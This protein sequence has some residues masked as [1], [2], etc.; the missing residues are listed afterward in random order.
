MNQASAINML[1]AKGFVVVKRTA[2]YERLQHPAHGAGSSVYVKQGGI[3][4]T[5]TY[6]LQWSKKV[7]ECYI[8]TKGGYEWKNDRADTLLAAI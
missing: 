6:A 1:M 3:G 5:G 2:Q 7:K 4:A 8:N